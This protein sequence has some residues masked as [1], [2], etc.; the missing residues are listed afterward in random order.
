[1]S[2]VIDYNKLAAR[3]LFPGI[4]ARI[5]H[6]DSMTVM[7]VTLEEDAILPEHHHPQEQWTNVIEGQLEMTIDGKT[8]VLEKGMVAKLLPNVPHSA[9]ALTRFIAIDV[10]TPPRNDLK[11]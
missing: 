8:S 9:R 5:D 11:E 1:M 3:E 10:F 7:H 6:T 4:V 2:F